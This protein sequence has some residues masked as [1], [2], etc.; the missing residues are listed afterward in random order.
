MPDLIAQYQRQFPSYQ[1]IT[2][3]F[4]SILSMLLQNQCLHIHSVTG[5]TKNEQSLAGKL[6]KKNDK[7]KQLTDITD[8]CGIRIITYYE[9][10]V[11]QIARLIREH[12]SIDEVN[13]IDKRKALA[14]NQFGYAS[15]HLIV[16]VPVSENG[17]QPQGTACCKIEIQIRSLLQHAW[18]EVEH[19]L[20]Y[21]NQAG[22]DEEAKRRF[23][24]LAAL[25]ELA[26][27]EMQG[28]RL[29]LEKPAAGALRY[30][31]PQ[32]VSDYHLPKPGFWQKILQ[33]FPNYGWAA[34]ASLAFCLGSLAVD[35]YFN[36]KLTHLASLF[37]APML[38]G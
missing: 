32:P 2:T 31:P 18:A 28:L 17:I 38:H 22:T 24:R 33:E 16:N 26:D 8:L 36:T 13:S 20:Q 37:S 21:K 19:D 7:Y 1:L 12:F 10:E 9:G 3:Q 23:S 25:L 30:I 5:R 4:Q 27:S 15:L 29:H 34:C 35:W 6:C 14:P 11:D